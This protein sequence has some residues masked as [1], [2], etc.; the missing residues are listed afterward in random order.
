M[1]GLFGVLDV[2]GRGLLVAQQGIG[3]TSNNIAN[4][5]T[6]GYSRQRQVVVSSLPIEKPNGNIGTG[7][8]QRSVE[9]IADAFIQAQLVKQRASSGSNDV[10]GSALARIEEV[11]N[12]QQGLGISGALSMLYDAFSELAAA[13]Q[14]GAAVE[15]EGVRSAALS[16][17]DVIHAA[18][19]QLRTQQADA[20]RAIQTMIPEINELTATIADL[21]RQIVE[22][23]GIAPANELRDQRDEAVRALAERIDIDT[24][25]DGSAQVV[26]LPSGMP[27]VEGAIANELVTL[28]D[29]SNPFD[30][31][32]SRVGFVG[33]GSPIDVTDDIGGGRL[34]GLL[35]VR[36]TLL[37][38]AIRSLDTIA[39]NL[40]EGVNAIHNTGIG[41]DGTVGDFFG[42]LPAVEDAARDITLD[43]N[44]LARTEAIAAGLTTAA[45]DNENARALAGVR[46]AAAPLYL[47]GDPPGAPSGPTRSLLVHTA[48]VVGDIGQ[49]SATMQN[50]RQ[51][52]TNL[53]EV[54]ENRRDELSGVSLDEEVTHLVQLQAAFQANARVMQAVDRLLE[55]VLS[56]V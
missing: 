9:R 22:S 32:F 13:P 36:D 31:T 14:P 35:R 24:F 30:P 4:V 25:E 37:P 52:D 8:E 17:L 11:F 46:D 56:I 55:D 20:D 18:D 6:P 50:I 44:I 15:R 12:E 29:T 40:V 33:S 26:V 38:S 43:V 47:P 16:V 49:Q 28:Q 48:S 5:N 7:A 2:A 23:E 41:L 34:G 10:Q 53:T 54:L 1:S 27:L 42:G 51:R 3:T 21:N 19:A 39:Y 45:G